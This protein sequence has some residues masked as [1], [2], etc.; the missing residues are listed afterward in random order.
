MRT[1]PRSSE[2]LQGQAR[3][4]QRD[5]SQLSARGREIPT[6]IERARSEVRRERRRGARAGD[7]SSSKSAQ[8]LV[9]RL[10]AELEGLP[11]A[12]HS[13]RLYAIE[14]GI[15][16]QEARRRELE[17][18]IREA[19]AE[20]QPLAD[21]ARDAEKVAQTASAATDATRRHEQ[22]LKQVEERGPMES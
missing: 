20:V 5:L 16:G 18:E 17:A 6:E 3:E 8:L 9:D 15:A 19:E 10:E 21:A 13:Q 22:T 7:P 4:A 11:E 2:D 1:T 14:V 12:I